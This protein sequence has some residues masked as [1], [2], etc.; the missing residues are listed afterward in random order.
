M[1]TSLVLAL[2]GVVTISFSFNSNRACGN[3]LLNGNFENNSAS[4]SSQLSNAQFNAVVA[5]ATAFGSADEIDLITST[6]FGIAPQSGNWK[7]GLHNQL[8][9]GFNDAFSATLS[10]PV[11]AAG[12]YHLRFFAALFG[13]RE[14]PLEIGLSNS[15]TNFGTLI[16]SA[17]PASPTSWTQFDHD[18]AAAAGASYLTVR[19][20]NSSGDIY[21]FIDNISLTEAVVPEPTMVLLLALG[22]ALLPLRVFRQ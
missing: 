7:I 16:F 21:A 22:L 9:T 17:T 13:Q 6:D 14:G 2:V 10:S 8:A 15:P 12:S 19:M 5:D 1:R 3:L 20:N 11:V 4:A 18:F